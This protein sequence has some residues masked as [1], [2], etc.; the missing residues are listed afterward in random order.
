MHGVACKL[1][2]PPLPKINL[3]A[4]PAE[5]AKAIS[6]AGHAVLGRGFYGKYSREMM[7]DGPC[8]LRQG[9]EVIWT[10]RCVSKTAERLTLEENLGHKLEG[11]VL[12]IESRYKARR[13]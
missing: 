7:E 10:R 1:P 4:L 9:D 11:D 8:V 5:A 6:S 3:N 13:K 2:S 12:N